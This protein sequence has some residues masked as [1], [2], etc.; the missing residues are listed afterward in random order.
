MNIKHERCLK[1]ISQKLYLLHAEYLPSY[2]CITCSIL[3]R[4]ETH[5]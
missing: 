1:C 4:S 5:G 3:L 2:M